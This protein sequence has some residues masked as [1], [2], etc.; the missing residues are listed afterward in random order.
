MKLQ[1]YKSYQQ[2]HIWTGIISGLL[3]F[4]CFVAGALTMFKAPLNIWAMHEKNAL[5]A[6]ELNQYDSL[7]KTVL[8][9]HPDASKEMTVYLPSAQPN[10]APVTW[11]I[12]D[13]ATHTH[14]FWHASLDSS[15]ELVSE[16][17]HIS[18]IGD[19]LDHI[20]RTAGIPGGDDHDALGIF[21]MGFV[22]ILYFVAIVS[23]LII[24]LPTWFKDL[25]S[26][27]KKKNGKRFWVDFHNILGITA[28]PF[29]IIIAITTVVFAYHDIL[30]GSMQQWV[31]KDSPMFN[32]PA[33]TEMNRG[34]DN[35]ISIAQLTKEITD[36]EPEFEIAELRFAGLGTP[37]ARVLVG[38]ELV[39]EIIRGPDY[40]FWVTDPYTAS[41]G[42]TAMLPS[43]SGVPGKVVNSFFTLHFGG[44]GG[45]FIHWVYFAMGLS[46]ALLFL[47]GNVVWVESRRKKQIQNKAPVEQKRSVRIMARLTIGVC[48]GAVVGIVLSLLAA[49][50]FSIDNPNI[51]T[52]QLI[53]YYIGFFTPVL[54]SFIVTPI[55]AAIDSL[56][57]S[58]LLLLAT[59][60][61]TLYFS[62]SSLSASIDIGVCL[63]SATILLALLTTARHL[64]K[65]RSAI[66]IDSVWA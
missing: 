42:Y 65:R 21:V 3:L 50:M 33:P 49:K 27:R 44:F 8:Q 37:R 55:K 48:A 43:I 63:V 57:L 53:A 35:L 7:I 36:I 58:S 51:R 18:A 20:H 34:V 31:Y 38:G 61:I 17:T 11:T 6:I 45:S 39:G 56:Y 1:N 62:S 25:F 2:V 66:P 26:L 60:G 52:Y 46:G 41:S 32:R 40:A 47:T 14:T 13:E 24:F 10:H 19:F 28:L 5:P 12:E 9:T 15:G 4:I 16:Q 64:Q 30:Y 22:S 59:I 23:G 29:H 54:Y